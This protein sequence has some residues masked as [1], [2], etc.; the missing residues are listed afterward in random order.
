[1]EY[2][3]INVSYLIMGMYSISLCSSSFIV[4]PSSLL[5][6]YKR[7]IKKKEELLHLISLI[8]FPTLPFSFLCLMSCIME[9]LLKCINAIEYPRE[10]LEVQVLDDSTD[11]SVS[12]TKSL[13]EKYKSEG[14]DIIQVR[15][16]NRVGFKAGALKE[17]LKSCK[18]ELVAIFDADFLPH[19]DWLLKTVPHFDQK[20]IGVVQTCW[21][22]SA[23]LFHPYEVQAFALDIFSRASG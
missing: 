7:P 19:P 4:W 9:R 17:G 16:E 23:R 6:N 2:F 1:M 12:L 21:S 3:W 20:D 13:V 14:L 18:G 22:P 11:E 8:K 15:R 5:S 10:R